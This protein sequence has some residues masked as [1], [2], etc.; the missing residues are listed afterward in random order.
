ML[1]LRTAEQIGDVEIGF[2]GNRGEEVFLERGEMLISE[3]NS[4]LSALPRNPTGKSILYMTSK[5]AVAGRQTQMDELITLAGYENF[6]PAPGWGT[7]PLERLAYER[8]D[9]IAAGFFE[10]S[11]LTSD[12]WTPARH[13]V[14]RRALTHA[15]IINIPGAWTAC[16][17]WFQ[18]DVVE[19]LI[20][21]TEK[22]ED[23]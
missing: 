5:G 14:A 20:D 3:M 10:T 22:S 2:V 17:G 15:S 16:G 6:Q 11:D 4:R 13:P 8:P 21:A 19:E 23:E 12:I 18:L 1:G 7:L 9:A